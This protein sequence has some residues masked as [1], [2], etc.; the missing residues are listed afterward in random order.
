[1]Q[2][3]NANG[4]AGQHRHARRPGEHERPGRQFLGADG[5]QPLIDRIPGRLGE[6]IQRHR[7]QKQQIDLVLLP[8]SSDTRLDGGISV[9]DPAVTA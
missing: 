1:M 9:S 2:A 3:C 5:P 6:L 7:G 4:D 8:T